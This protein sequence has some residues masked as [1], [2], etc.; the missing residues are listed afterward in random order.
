MFMSLEP[1]QM[2]HRLFDV[3]MTYLQTKL[4]ENS[5]PLDKIRILS[6]SGTGAAAFLRAPAMM[7]GAFFSSTEFQIAVK[8]R[9]KASLN[10]LCPPTCV[11]GSTIDEHGSH[12]FKCR[13]GGEWNHRHSSIVHLLASIMRSVQLTVQHEVP[14]ANLGPLQA[15]DREGN[16]RMDLVVTPCDSQPFLADV[17]ITHPAPSQPSTT[18]QTMYQPLYFAKHHEN[19]KRRKYEEAVRSIN[20]RFVPLALE[21]FGAMGPCFDKCLK[22]LAARQAL[23]DAEKSILMRFWRMK[24]SCCLQKANS[25]LIMSKAQRVR[26]QSRQGSAPLAPNL[27]EAWRIT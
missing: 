16:G 7:Q 1:K 25:F 3:Y 11:C 26:K 13:I 24:I 6:C 12:F 5:D 18:N 2:Q 19:R 4:I 23:T 21:T 10:L 22:S 14:L 20:S 9:I 8:I 17:T 15:L 27:T